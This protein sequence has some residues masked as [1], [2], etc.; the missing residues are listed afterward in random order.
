VPAT[1]PLPRSRVVLALWLEDD[2]ATMVEYGIMIGLIALVCILAI[3]FVGEQTNT[4]FS[5]QGLLDA[6]GG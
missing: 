6:L 2:G 1:H 5:N 4:N 3:Q